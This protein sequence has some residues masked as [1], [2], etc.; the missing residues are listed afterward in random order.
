VLLDCKETGILVLASS[1]GL[2]G[3]SCFFLL[4]QESAIQST[5]VTEKVIRWETA[6]EGMQRQALLVNR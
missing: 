6:S 2:I 1:S 4:L 3:L 5:A